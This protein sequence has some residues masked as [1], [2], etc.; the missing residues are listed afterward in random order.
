MIEKTDEEIRAIADPLW[1]D[2][3]RCSNEGKYEEFVRNFAD[4]QSAIVFG[5]VQVADAGAAHTVA[6]TSAIRNAEAR[7]KPNPLLRARWMKRRSDRPTCR[8]RAKP[9]LPSKNMLP[10]LVLRV[11][12]P[13]DSV[14]GFP[15]A[16][17]QPLLRRIPVLRGK[18]Q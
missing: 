5:T 3:L 16:A 17:E 14:A 2:L 6:P 10:P 15:A 18:L 4:V 7:K 1:R 11:R 13:S 12:K 9:A 8:A